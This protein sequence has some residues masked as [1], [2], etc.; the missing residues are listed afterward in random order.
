[1]A[2]ECQVHVNLK[3][4]ESFEFVKNKDYGMFWTKPSCVIIVIGSSVLAKESMIRL[5]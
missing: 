2:T 3:A 5:L 1:M 4:F